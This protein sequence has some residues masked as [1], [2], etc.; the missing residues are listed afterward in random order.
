MSNVPLTSTT[1]LRDLACDTQHARWGEFV[2]RYRPM[3]S[4]FMFENFP[5]LDADDVIQETLISLIRV[6]PVYHY[7]PDEKG[8]FHNYLTGILRHKALRALADNNREESM[9][10]ELKSE[11]PEPESAGADEELAYKSW[12]D[13]V[14]E[15]ALKQYLA[16]ETV[17]EL[18]KQVFT[19]LAVNG[20]KPNDIACAFGIE[21]NAVDQIKSRAM[22]RLRK[23]VRALEQVDDA[24]IDT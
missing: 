2:A 23:L 20:E 19:R 18:T 24:R 4:T 13:S 15:I 10:Q 6:F 1:L 3:M 7:V 9:R 5:S 14:F 22:A 11:A 12:R 8:S 16:D 21:R 17:S